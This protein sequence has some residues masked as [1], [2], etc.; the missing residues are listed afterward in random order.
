MSST[1]APRGVG[2]L[3]FRARVLAER[4]SGRSIFEAGYYRESQLTRL[5]N[6]FAHVDVE[7]LRGKRILEVG[8]GLGHLGD[9]FTQLGFDVTSTDGRR[10]HVQ[11]MRE[12]GR[13]S[14]MLDL[15]KTKDLDLLAGDDKGPFDIVLSFGVLYHLAHPAEFLSACAEK[16]KILFLE[17]AVSDH[18]EPV[19]DWVNEPG[20]WRGQDQAMAGLACRPSPAW[21]ERTSR[22]AG[23]DKVRD[24]ST[25]LGNWT[26]GSFDWE[27]RND[28]TWRRDGM[29]LRKMWVCE[30][31]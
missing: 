21:V 6:L 12:R 8:S 18:V 2:R 29:N 26:V 22:E 17:T 31:Q 28:G 11:S 7:S 19:V 23:F 3:P 27:S 20:G 13:Q 25:P 16:T 1:P 5:M 4:L 30:N 15:D 14:F 9:A 24:I 10:E